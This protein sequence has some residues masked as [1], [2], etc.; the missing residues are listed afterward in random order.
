[1]PR[2]KI[3]RVKNYPDEKKIG[4]HVT[5]GCYGNPNIKTHANWEVSLWI[6]GFD[7]PLTAEEELQGLFYKE[8]RKQA[9]KLARCLDIPI[10]EVEG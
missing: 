6:V 2:A 4:S 8:A 10:C 5:I 9:L 1:M 3:P 7:M